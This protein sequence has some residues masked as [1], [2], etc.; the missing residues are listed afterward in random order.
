MP[1]TLLM[2]NSSR[3]RPTPAFGI[4]ANSKASSGLPTFIMTF[5]GS[6][7]SA[8]V[9]WFHHLV[10]E[11]A[12]IDVA[13]IALGAG[14]GDRL[15]ILQHFGGVAA[16]DDGRDAQFARDDGGV[17]GAPAA[18]GDDGRGALHHR[19]PV[20]VGHVGHQHVARLHAVHFRRVLDDAHRADADLLRRWRGRWP[21]PCRTASSW[22]FSVE[23]ACI[24]CDFTVSGR[25][26]RM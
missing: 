26:W 13:G 20:R 23:L 19:L 17:A 8:P 21:A 11:A 22:N 18:V 9:S 2:M 15:A 24:C 1:I 25:A 7:G 12:A 16:A 4:C 5:T 6:S 14:D 10:F 3:A